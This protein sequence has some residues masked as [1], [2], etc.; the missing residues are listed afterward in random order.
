M[1]RP[2]R[3]ARRFVTEDQKIRKLVVAIAAL[4]FL[5]GCFTTS[6]Y[7][8]PST[9]IAS[10]A[11]ILASAS[12][13]AKR[14]VRSPESVASSALQT[15]TF[16]ER[17]IYITPDVPASPVRSSVV[18][19]D[20]DQAAN[21]A[22]FSHKPAVHPVSGKPVRA[23]IVTCPQCRLN[24]LP[25]VKQFVMNEAKLFA[26]DLKIDFIMGKDPHLFLYEDDKELEAIDL[27][28]R[29]AAQRI[30]TETRLKPFLQSSNLANISYAIDLSRVDTFPSPHS[31]IRWPDNHAEAY[32]L[33]HHAEVHNI[34]GQGSNVGDRLEASSTR[35]INRVMCTTLVSCASLHCL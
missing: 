31:A 33:R 1:I 16:S 8:F 19:A 6:F 9:P 23:L 32:P 13:D 17:A 28:V 34:R 7:T 15:A 14:I 11:S 27:A 24:S 35:C 3:G 21:Q 20:A 18:E 5:L 12:A 30:Y 25:K 2:F 29:T 22:K 10:A 4:V 26:P